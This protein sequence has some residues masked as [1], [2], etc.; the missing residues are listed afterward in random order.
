MYT[1][2]V[3]AAAA[4][5]AAVC[6]TP[7]GQVWGA[8]AAGSTFISI[9]V[10]ASAFPRACCSMHTRT[11]AHTHTQDDDKTKKRTNNYILFFIIRWGIE[12]TGR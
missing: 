2:A 11:R 10:V 8:R 9:V 4:C 6:G 1:W 3:A 7:L 12:G 5:A